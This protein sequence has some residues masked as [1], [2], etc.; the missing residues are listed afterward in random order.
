MRYSATLLA[1]S[2]IIMDKGDFIVLLK[3]LWC[4]PC[5][6]SIFIQSMVETNSC[7]ITSASVLSCLI[8][9]FCYSKYFP[10]GG[11]RTLYESKRRSPKQV[12]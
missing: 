12:K 2:I 9:I 3:E 7:E 8:I 11:G 6:D 10:G 5:M 4:L 1:F